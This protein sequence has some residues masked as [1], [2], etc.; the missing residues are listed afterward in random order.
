MIQLTTETS[1][2]PL[3]STCMR[4]YIS[5]LRIK[6]YNPIPNHVYEIKCPKAL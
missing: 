5:L 6:H 4:L 2:D 1:Q 3:I